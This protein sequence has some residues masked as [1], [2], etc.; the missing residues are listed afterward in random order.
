[1]RNKRG[2]TIR[3]RSYITVA[4]TVAAVAAC[5][6]R[7]ALR[8]TLRNGFE[9]CNK[10]LRYCYLFAD[11]RRLGRARFAKFSLAVNVAR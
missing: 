3:S 10:L 6:T 4:A 11:P 9:Y 5:P 1:M 7:S 8:N 2:Q